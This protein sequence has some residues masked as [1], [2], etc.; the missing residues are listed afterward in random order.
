[1]GWWAVRHTFGFLLG[2]LLTP[3]LAYGGAWGYV[4]AGAAYDALN[5]TISDR[6]RMYGSFALLA[7]VGLVVG[8][9]VLARW[10]SPF[11]SLVPA[12]AFIAWSAYFLAAPA[13]ALRVTEKLPPGGQLDSG[14]RMLLGYGVFAVLG[15]ALLVP[16]WAPGR[17]SGRAQPDEPTG[18]DGSHPRRREF[19]LFD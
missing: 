9:V 3:A 10:A 2:V 1:M 14:L 5:Q 11:V 15:F 17:W 7:A 4:Q 16:A 13:A 19:D 18:H 12:I 8:I 6:T